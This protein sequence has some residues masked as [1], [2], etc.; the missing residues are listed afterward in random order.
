MFKLALVVVLAVAACGGDDT[1]QAQPDA[2][3]NGPACTKALYDICA[4]NTDCTSG[5]CHYYMQSNFSVCTQACSASNPCPN[6]ANGTPGTCNNMGICKPA[7]ANN[8]HL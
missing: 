7:V 1:Q 2:A 3:M 8:C 5:N 6:D 4:T